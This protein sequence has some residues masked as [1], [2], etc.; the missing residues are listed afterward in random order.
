MQHSCRLPVPSNSVHV[1]VMYL[2][3]MFFL[4]DLAADHGQL[5]YIVFVS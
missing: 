4:V 5:P 2:L 3:I 1:H